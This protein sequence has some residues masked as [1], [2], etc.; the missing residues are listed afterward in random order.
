MGTFKVR[1]YPRESGSF[2][3]AEALEEIEKTSRKLY[4][5]TLEAIVEL[6]SVQSFAGTHY[7]KVGNKLWCLRIRHGGC[8]ARIF[9]TIKKGVIWLLNGYVK[10]SNKIPLRKLR[11]AI[12][13][14]KEVQYA[15]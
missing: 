4:E 3:T 14:M 13:L 2:P 5:A 10:K 1:L 8:W 12:K 9:F 7:E 11:L 15:R 6:E